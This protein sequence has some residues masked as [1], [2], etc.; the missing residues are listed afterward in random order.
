MFLLL[1]NLNHFSKIMRAW[2]SHRPANT[3]NFLL[4]AVVRQRCHLRA[5]YSQSSPFDSTQL[6]ESFSPPSGSVETP[7]FRRYRSSKAS[8]YKVGD[9][10]FGGS[11]A[12]IELSTNCVIIRNGLYRNDG[13][14]VECRRDTDVHT[15]N[16][17]TRIF[18][19]DGWR[20]VMPLAIDQ[21]SRVRN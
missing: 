1:V 3:N 7:L 9:M 19:A 11:I 21:A 17:P 20:W 2:A 18:T 16:K 6:A 15:V 12:G 5:M 4:T 8:Q 14:P 10:L 13:T